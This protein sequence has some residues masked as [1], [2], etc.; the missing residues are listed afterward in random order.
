[1]RDSAVEREFDKAFPRLSRAAGNVIRWHLWDQQD[2][3]DAVGETLTRVFDRW[4]RAEGDREAFTRGVAVNVCHEFNRKRRHR[5]LEGLEE[6][7]ATASHEDSVLSAI[8]VN[9]ALQG[10]RSE[11]QRTVMERRFLDDL[12]EPQAARLLGLTLKQ[13]KTA[14]KDGR[15][16]LQKAYSKN[17][18]RS[19]GGERP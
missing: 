12:T 15:R 8:T 2:H 9:Q 3:E 13:V 14:G 1:M 4:E 6:H 19:S 11:R 10:V 18:R 7:H 16:A 5:D 17:G